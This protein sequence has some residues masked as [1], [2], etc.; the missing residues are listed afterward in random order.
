M[1]T[2]FVQEMRARNAVDALQAKVAPRACTVRDGQEG[3]VLVTGAG[4]GRRGENC[5]RV[6]WCRRTDD[7]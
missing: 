2:N 7:F 4:A 6:I 1:V 3:T 5:A